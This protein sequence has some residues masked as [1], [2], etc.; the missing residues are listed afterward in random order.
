MHRKGLA[1]KQSYFASVAVF[2]LSCLPNTGTAT[3]SDLSLVLAID[4]SGSIDAD[5]FI[6]QNIGY[7]AAFESR[8]VKQALSAAGIVD[9]AAVYWADADFAFQIIPWYRLTTA[10]D[11]DAFSALFL[12]IARPAIG[13][14]DIGNGLNVA[15]DMIEEPN[16]CSFRKIVNVS[17]DGIESG[18]AK[19]NIFVPLSV[20][21]AR[22]SELG[23]IVNGLAIENDV[24]ELSQYYR[25]EL[26]SGSG[27]FVIKVK[28]FS[29]FRVAIEQKL[30][31]EIGLAL[32]SSLDLKSY[33]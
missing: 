20:A 17:G 7:A 29:A 28:D 21:R 30:A 23:I 22:A 15:I 10:Q 33:H 4:S 18:S 14:T 19:Q 8:S 2:C 32:Y 26:I 1:M 24:P 12:S 6:L 27:S 3:C 9:V 16:R 11:A 31:R 5:E 25:D 13:D